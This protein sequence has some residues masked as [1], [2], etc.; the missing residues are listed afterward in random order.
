ML[1]RHAPVSQL[2]LA[3]D[4]SVQAPT[5]SM[6]IAND[7]TVSAPAQT[8]DSDVAATLVQLQ[9]EGNRDDSGKAEHGSKPAVETQKDPKRLRQSNHRD[10]W[11][12]RLNQEYEQKVDKAT[13]EITGESPCLEGGRRNA[14]EV[15][16]D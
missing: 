4:V 10:F 7:H 12:I 6:S 3:S 16:G 14:R 15:A 5:T 1:K 13:I 11:R 8:N 2:A 9:G